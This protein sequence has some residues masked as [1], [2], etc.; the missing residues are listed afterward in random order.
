MEHTQHLAVSLEEAWDYFSNPVNL[1]DITPKW[2][3]FRVDSSLPEKIYPGLI[4]TYQIKPIARIP[5]TW[6]TEVTH[7]KE[8]E[9]FVNEQRFGPYAFWHHQHH[10]RPLANSVEM[11]DIIHYGVPFGMVG[12]MLHP[13]LVEKKVKDIFEYRKKKIKNI[14]Q[15]IAEN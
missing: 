5:L 14:F 15:P 10:F 9:Y 8:N 4:L 1:S 12:R 11:T 13:L 6:A 7:I 2:L 3:H